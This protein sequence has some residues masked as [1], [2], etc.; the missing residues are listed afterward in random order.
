MDIS[1]ITKNVSDELN[2]HHQIS[3]MQKKQRTVGSNFGSRLQNRMA[4]DAG[5]DNAAQWNALRMQEQIIKENPDLA[6]N[7]FS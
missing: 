1:D 7:L 4:K 6:L 2:I 3:P 5:F